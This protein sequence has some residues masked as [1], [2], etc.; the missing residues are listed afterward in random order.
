MRNAK[1]IA[2]VLSLALDVHMFLALPLANSAT[3]AV[4]DT[5][6]LV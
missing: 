1:C 6:A 4:N 2:V 5:N 3:T